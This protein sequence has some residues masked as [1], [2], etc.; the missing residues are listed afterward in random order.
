MFELSTGAVTSGL[1]RSLADEI[2]KLALLTTE[3][4]L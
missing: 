3:I 1:G 4:R 2:G